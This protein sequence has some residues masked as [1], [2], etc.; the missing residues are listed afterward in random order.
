M[1][2]FDFLPDL[3]HNC[4]CTSRDIVRW[5]LMRIGWGDNWHQM[6][7]ISA[8][9]S[10]IPDLIGKTRGRFLGHFQKNRFRPVPLWED[11]KKLKKLAAGRLNLYYLVQQWTWSC[12]WVEL[13]RS[14]DQHGPGDTTDK[15][16]CIRID[17]LLL[18][19]EFDRSKG[20][21]KRFNIGNWKNYQTKKW[22]ETHPN[23]KSHQWLDNRWANAHTCRP[24]SV[25]FQR[26]G[27]PDLRA[28]WN[29]WP[30]EQTVYPC[31]CHHSRA[32]SAG[33]MHF[34]LPGNLELHRYS[35][36]K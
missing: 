2:K 22:P 11:E 28:P 33:R 16:H 24:D 23:V 8:I 20:Q 17:S 31:Q 25:K 36:T 14:C 19:P 27:V 26:C 13:T 3:F 4:K 7:S 15:S 18:C 30:T 32:W 12:V 6:I 34:Q 5:I 1:K 21:A 29:Y 35:N 9:D 10:R